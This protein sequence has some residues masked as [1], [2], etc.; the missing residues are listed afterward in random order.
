M[1]GQW[2]AAA[3]PKGSH[4]A[5]VRKSD[6]QPARVGRDVASAEAD[7]ALQGPKAIPGGST[8]GAVPERHRGLVPHAG[9]T[10]SARSATDAQAVHAGPAA[11][12]WQAP[13]GW[14]GLAC[15]QRPV[16]E[17]V[18]EE[19]ERRLRRAG[20]IRSPERVRELGAVTAAASGAGQPSVVRP[21][22]GA[23]PL[24]AAA[25]G[26][27]SPR[28]GVGHGL[29]DGATVRPWRGAMA[30]MTTRRRGAS[31]SV[32]ARGGGRDGDEVTAPRLAV[33]RL[34]GLDAAQG[35]Q[36]IPACA[37]AVWARQCRPCNAE[38]RRLVSRWRKARDFAWG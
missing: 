18:G 1:P 15:K 22:V 30:S 24:G 38:I 31:A 33:L 20:V 13:G 7:Q 5:E 29:E 36:L 32:R 37:P 9:P 26:C 23:G 3:T 27:A 19:L 11:A 10:G 4:R 14:A 2:L 8:P 34:R 21:P 16:R 17:R 28:T 6:R 25:A 12:R 35:C